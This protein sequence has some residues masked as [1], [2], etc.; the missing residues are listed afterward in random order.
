MLNKGTVRG[1]GT[2]EELKRKELV[3]SIT[4]IDGNTRKA[5]DSNVAEV[6]SE[7]G[8][9]CLQIPMSPVISIFCITAKT[10][11]KLNLITY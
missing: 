11:Y 3:T 7:P 1:L 9:P 2:Y 10:F 8:I 6:L 4:Q 5:L